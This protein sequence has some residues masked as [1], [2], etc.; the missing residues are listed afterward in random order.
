MTLLRRIPKL[1]RLLRM[2]P[3]IEPW[4]VAGLAIISH[5][6][7]G[8]CRLRATLPTGSHGVE[9]RHFLEAGPRL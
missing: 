3:I 2:E 6:L 1:G 8:V 5:G 4:A 7:L 9:G